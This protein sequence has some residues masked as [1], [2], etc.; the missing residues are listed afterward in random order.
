MTTEDRKKE[1][2]GRNSIKSK[3]KW[4]RGSG[5]EITFSLPENECKSFARGLSG[6][7]NRTK[8]NPFKVL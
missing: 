7:W 5:A 4:K 6:D 3:V 2:G 8:R 1:K